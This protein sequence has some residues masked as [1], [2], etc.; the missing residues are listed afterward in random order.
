LSNEKIRVD[1]RGR[2]LLFG[3]PVG[4][5]RKGEAAVDSGCQAA[6]LNRF[7]MRHCDK[8]KFQYGLAEKLQTEYTYETAHLIQNARLWQLKPTAD[9]ALMF[10]SYS[11]LIRRKTA[12]QKENYDVTFDGDISTSDPEKAYSIFRNRPA[13]ACRGHPITLSDVIELY[14]PLQ[15]RF[16]Y[17]DRFALK[18]IEF[19]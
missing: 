1:N 9:T 12:V 13:T 18:Q 16:Y 14:N 3:R 10:A 11:D 7:L 17:V 4:I 6:E 2:I 15:S 5:I 19:I 8:V